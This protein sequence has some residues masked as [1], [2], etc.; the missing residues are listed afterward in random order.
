MTL[1]L[2]RT[3]PAMFVLMTLLARPEPAYSSGEAPRKPPVHASTADRLSTYS[4]RV[5]R[6]TINYLRLKLLELHE[7]GLDR[8]RAA[9]ERRLSI[10]DLF[11]EPAPAAKTD[12]LRTHPPLP[13]RSP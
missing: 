5:R 6:S 3:L 7:A 4:P 11:T 13:Q 9:I 10:D 2:A 8:A 1:T 12:V